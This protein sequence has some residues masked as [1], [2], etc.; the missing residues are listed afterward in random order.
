MKRKGSHE[1]ECS[2]KDEQV[3][4]SS[5]HSSSST[6]KAWLPQW[7]WNDLPPGPPFLVK[8]MEVGHTDDG[9]E[10]V[11]NCSLYVSLVVKTEIA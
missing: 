4:R 1:G 8:M 3:S 9:V 2:H 10:W 11:V 7:L 6:N 5:Q